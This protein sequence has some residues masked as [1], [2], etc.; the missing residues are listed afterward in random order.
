M[1]RA[2]RGAESALSLRAR[3]VQIRVYRKYGVPCPARRLSVPQPLSAIQCREMEEITKF[4]HAEGEPCPHLAPLFGG[5]G[6][7]NALL[8]AA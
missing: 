1:C 8:F 7:D 5:L 3:I 4:R 2:Y 6:G